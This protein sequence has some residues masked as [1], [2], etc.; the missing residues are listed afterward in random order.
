ML[1]SLDPVLLARIQFAFTIFYELCRPG[2]QHVAVAGPIRSHLP[3]G[4]GSTGV[5]IVIA[6]WNRCHAAVG[7]HVYGL[8]LLHL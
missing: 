4:G 8:L 3:A 5:P 6:D 2:Y 1:A 7:T